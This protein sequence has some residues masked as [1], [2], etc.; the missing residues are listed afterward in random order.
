MGG[1]AGVKDIGTM[2]GEDKSAKLMPLLL[3]SD[4]G[5]NKQTTEQGKIE[6]LSQWTMDG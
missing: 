2:Q 6:L 1:A 4:F 3:L 5:Y